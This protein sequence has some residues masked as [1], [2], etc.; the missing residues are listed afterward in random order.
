M[1]NQIIPPDNINIERYDVNLLIR[2]K[3]LSSQ[4]WLKPRIIKLT[5][6]TILLTSITIF[7]LLYW[8]MLIV[9]TGEI[10][11]P[12]TF[13]TIILLAIDIYIGY[14]LIVLYFNQIYIFGDSEQITISHNF[15][16][17]KLTQNLIRNKKLRVV[18]LKRFYS[19]KLKNYP[20]RLGIGPLFAVYAS[21]HTGA[22]KKLITVA[23]GEEALFLEKTLERFYQIE[24]EPQPGEVGAPNIK[25]KKQP[26]V[27]NFVETLTPPNGITVDESDGKLLIIQKWS[28]QNFNRYSLIA[29]G[30]LIYLIESIIG[31]QIYS[32]LFTIN[33]IT[34]L[35]VFL[36][37][38]YFP[39]IYYS[40]A[41][42]I[43]RTYISADEEEIT[44]NHKPLPLPDVN[45]AKIQIADLKRLYS[46]N[47][48]IGADPFHHIYAEG[49]TG[50]ETELLFL[51]RGEE[52]LFIEKMLER[53]CNIEDEP[54]LG[55]LGAP[56]IKSKRQQEATKL[57]QPFELPSYLKID[58]TSS[59]LTIKN[60]WLDRNIIGPMLAFIVLNFS[61]IYIIIS[62]IL[63]VDAILSLGVFCKTFLFLIVTPLLLIPIYFLYDT[64]VY[65]F[66]QTEIIANDEEIIVKDKP[67]PCF[68]SNN[69]AI[70][71]RQPFP[72]I[73]FN[74]QQP[75]VKIK[76]T[77]LK[78]LYAT[79]ELKRLCAKED[80][81]NELPDNIRN[82]RYLGFKVYAI[83]HTGRE[84]IL[85]SLRTRKEAL[86][87]EGKLETYFNIE[88]EPQEGELDATSELISS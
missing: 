13:L 61:F 52:A 7:L 37:I 79:K 59:K 81:L 58:E 50:A 67:I 17:Q 69:F 60:K 56:N 65:L 41:M 8:I 32:S 70:L 76:A 88:D 45:Q 35:I 63:I 38:L 44:I 87:I 62:P 31:I 5:K 68:W 25:P 49:K 22:D 11:D 42:D 24:D 3:W 53:H 21:T 19:K 54:Q 75:R 29:F 84:E 80:P 77:N 74:R 27:T 40:I 34:Y 43:N 28:N 47:K 66:N 51:R 33:Q 39:V 48:M 16:A 64:I 72:S 86:F 83:T 9:K 15:P 82:C 71:R 30:V 4:N 46:S 78:R 73:Q 12:L 18:N 10:D 57:I 14:F 36:I 26:N 20:R 1:S 6:F 55:E 23:S 85:V 2:I